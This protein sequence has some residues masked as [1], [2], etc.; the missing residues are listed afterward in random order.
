LGSL[1]YKRLSGCQPYLDS[2][3][4]FGL[5]QVSGPGWP[6]FGRTTALNAAIY[7]EVMMSIPAGQLA[8]GLVA[9]GRVAL[10]GSDGGGYPC[11]HG[12]VG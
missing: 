10:Y 3:L 12:Q 1:E 2:Y 5:T 11:G 4:A 9:G 6:L 8:Y 7:C